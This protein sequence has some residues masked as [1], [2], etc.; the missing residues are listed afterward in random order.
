MGFSFLAV[1]DLHCCSSF[2]LVVM[3]RNY[4]PLTVWGSSLQWLL[5]LQNTG[6]R[7]ASV[8]VAYRLSGCSSLAL[9]CWLSSCV[10]RAWL[11]HSKWDPPMSP[12][13]AGRYFTT[14][15]PG[16]HV[17]VFLNEWWW[18]S[19]KYDIKIPLDFLRWYNFIF[20]CQYLQGYIIFK[21]ILGK[22]TY[23][24]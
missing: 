15:P 7:W 4:S 6:S 12:A 16:K 13:L 11:F 24:V 14:K 22:N 23:I 17:H 8:T 3:S 1:L 9:E 5:L 18:I 2:S 19:N 21:I 10:V 20:V